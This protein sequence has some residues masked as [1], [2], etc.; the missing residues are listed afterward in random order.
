MNDDPDLRYDGAT[1][2]G[3]VWTLWLLRYF[4]F[5]AEKSDAAMTY[6]ALSGI[7]NSINHFHT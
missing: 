1:L 7:L 3:T 6:Y 2:H 5:T 4:T